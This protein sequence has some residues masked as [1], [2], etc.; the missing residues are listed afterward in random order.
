[1]N[2][3]LTKIPSPNMCFM[4]RQN[5]IEYP[6]L[7]INEQSMIF[8]NYSSFIITMLNF[9]E[10]FDIIRR[11]FEGQFHGTYSMLKIQISR[12][13]KKLCFIEFVVTLT[14]L[15]KHITI[16]LLYAFSL[17]IQPI[18]WY[19]TCFIPINRPFLTHWLVLTTENF[20]LI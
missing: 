3:D 2:F 20:L 1:M 6:N 12:H 9:P 17:S 7:L 14:Y 8:Y 18:R 16:I 19:L 4:T 11:N 10:H 13:K 15:C 5:K